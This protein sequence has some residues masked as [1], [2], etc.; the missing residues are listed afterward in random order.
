MSGPVCR[1]PSSVRTHALAD[2]DGRRADCADRRA[3]LWRCG[4]D[5]TVGAAEIIPGVGKRVIVNK[6]HPLP[7][8]L[9]SVVGNLRTPA[10][11][12]LPR[13]MYHRSHAS[14]PRAPHSRHQHGNLTPPSHTQHGASLLVCFAMPCLSPFLHVPSQ[15]HLPPRPSC[16]ETRAGPP[17]SA[18]GL[19]SVHASHPAACPRA[20]AYNKTSMH[21]I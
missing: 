6:K 5:R 9:C 19:C 4:R 18:Q 20:Y 15:A 12:Y 16:G 2:L 1:G 14:C 21:V 11:V 10:W 8:L 13:I 7:T 17:Y 3:P